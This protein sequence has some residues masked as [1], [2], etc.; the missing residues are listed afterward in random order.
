MLIKFQMRVDKEKYKPVWIN[1][2][3]VVSVVVGY[4]R[5]YEGHTMVTTCALVGEDENECWIVQGEPEDVVKQLEFP[6]H[7]GAEDY[8]GGAKY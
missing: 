3:Y 5:L 6:P 8:A 1:P 2:K 7:G 4:K